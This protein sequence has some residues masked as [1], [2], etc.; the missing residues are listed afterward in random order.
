MSIHHYKKL[1]V[2]AFSFLIAA[3]NS[4]VKNEK[5]NKFLAFVGVVSNKPD[6]F[7]NVPLS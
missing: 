4:I 1:F 5:F 6:V 2:I 3:C 7:Y